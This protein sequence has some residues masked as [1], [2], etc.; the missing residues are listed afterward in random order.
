M[1]PFGTLPVRVE[2]V[3]GRV[4]YHIRP[5]GALYTYCGRMLGPNPAEPRRRQ[6]GWGRIPE[7]SRCALCAARFKRL[8][9]G[10]GSR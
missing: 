3:P 2:V 6:A 10:R 9:R 1:L 5:A 7:D 4:R 8:R